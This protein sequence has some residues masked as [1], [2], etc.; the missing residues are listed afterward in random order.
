M[1][2]EHVIIGSEDSEETRLAL[3]DIVKRLGLLEELERERHA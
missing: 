1:T 3:L 2:V